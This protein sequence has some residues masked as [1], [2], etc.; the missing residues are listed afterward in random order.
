MSTQR[1]LLLSFIVL[2][3]LVAQALDNLLE[4]LFRAVSFLGFLNQKFQV[5]G[6]DTWSYGTLIGYGGALALALYCWR[7]PKVREPAEQVVEEMTRVTWPTVAETRA[8]TY[9]VIVATLISAVILGFFDYGW[10]LLTTM[11]YSSH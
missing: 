6:L 11:I 5:P 3:S 7:A 4:S 8:A 1:I 2:G 10:G 9:A